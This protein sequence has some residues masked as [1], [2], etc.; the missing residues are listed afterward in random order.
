M[1][2]PEWVP[3]HYREGRYVVE[4]TPIHESDYSRV[5]LATDQAD[6]VREEDRTVVL[7]VLKARPGSS[8]DH[9]ATMFEREVAA[10]E[11]LKHPGIIRMLDHFIERER[12][13]LC[14]V[15]E[16]LPEARSLDEVMQEGHPPPSLAERLTMLLDLAAAIDH[17]HQ[18]NIVHRDINPSNVLITGDHTVKLVDFGISQLKTA[19][20]RARKGTVRRFH[21]PPF[22]PYEQYERGVVSTGCDWYAFGML[23][24]TTLAWEYPDEELHGG[25]ILTFAGNIQ[26]ALRQPDVARRLENV[27]LRLVTT[28]E[29]E[30]PKGYEIEAVLREALGC[31]TRKDKLVMSLS[32]RAKSDLVDL[33]LELKH[34]LSDLNQHPRVKLTA[35]RHGQDPSQ[36]QILVFGPRFKA[37]LSPMTRSNGLQLIRCWDNGDDLEKHERVRS[38]GLEV[39]VTFEVGA[40]PSDATSLVEY[41]KRDAAR[42]SLEAKEWARREGFIAVAAAVLEHQ[43]ERAGHLHLPYRIPGLVMKQGVLPVR[44][45]QLIELDLIAGDLEDEDIPDHL[46]TQEYP[47]DAAFFES[48]AGERSRVLLPGSTFSFATV[49]SFQADKRTLTLAITR[50]CRLRAEGILTCVDTATLAPIQRQEQALNR[51]V[52][53]QGANSSLADL[54]IEPGRNSLA[55]KQNR[56]M[57]QPFLRGDMQMADIVDRALSARD[58]SCF[59]DP[60]GQGKPRSSRRS[61]PRFFM[62]SRMPRFC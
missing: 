23:I 22:A 4:A 42:R 53:D 21:T 56:Q 5:L 37:V 30:R 36:Y 35:A 24:A 31:V 46:S 19:L 44:P 52:R 62:N 11:D 40:V 20:R 27:L 10:L 25:Q 41:L 16:F 17:A 12:N 49:H 54:V 29:H 47:A 34:V 59:R 32:S 51:F 7:K 18:C 2:Y 14:I 6:H 57:L 39:Y 48:E 38:S 26:D 1:L 55:P 33:G 50:K 43:R 58:F 60:Q 8:N 13:E 9:A 61:W 3:E 45:G 15:L 28:S